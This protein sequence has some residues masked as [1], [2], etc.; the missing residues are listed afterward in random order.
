MSEGKKDLAWGETPFDEFSR[1]DLLRECQRM[2][3]ALEALRTTARLI[4][5]REEHSP[6]WGR[7]GTGGRALEMARQVLEPIQSRYEPETIFRSF[8]RYATDLLFDSSTGFD[9]GFGWAVCPECGDMFGRDGRGRSA[10]GDSC[11]SHWPKT[12]APCS[13]VLRSLE[14]QDLTKQETLH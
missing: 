14:W 8:F 1:E 9:I 12:N 2:Y 10:V 11:A 5:I 4:Q 13:G 6:F 7:S 3:A